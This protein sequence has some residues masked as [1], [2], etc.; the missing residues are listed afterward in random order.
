MRSLTEPFQLNYRSKNMRQTQ[1]EMTWTYWWLSHPF[2]TCILTSSFL[3]C[4]RTTNTK[5]PFV[6]VDVSQTINDFYSRQF[7]TTIK[8]LPV[9]S[10]TRWPLGSKYKTSE[11]PDL[12]LMGAHW[13]I[14]LKGTIQICLEPQMMEVKLCIMVVTMLGY[15][16]RKMQKRLKKILF[17]LPLEVWV[18]EWCQTSNTSTH[19]M[20][21]S[22]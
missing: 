15:T 10:S 11:K 4:R 1:L 22:W 9:A 14:W 16:Y 2:W 12:W 5:Q 19:A 21:A 17:I 13:W 6:L 3:R 18:D 8:P 20:Q 7:K